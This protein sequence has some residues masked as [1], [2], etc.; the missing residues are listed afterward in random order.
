MSGTTTAEAR[1]AGTEFSVEALE[2]LLRELR[3]IA[4]NGAKLH[5]AQPTRWHIDTYLARAR[6]KPN[7]AAR[8]RRLNPDG[9]A[10]GEWPRGWHPSRMDAALRPDVWVMGPKEFIAT[11]GRSAYRRA[12]KRRLFSQRGHHKWISRADVKDRAWERG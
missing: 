7:V 9:I 5:L 4:E 10:A 1:L 8:I 6:H 3:H 11:F 2:S 12:R